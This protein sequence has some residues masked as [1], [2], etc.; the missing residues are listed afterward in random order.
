METEQKRAIDVVGA[1]LVA[2]DRIFYVPSKDLIKKSI[3]T[4][5]L[6]QYMQSELVNEFLEKRKPVYLGTSTGGSA[7]N[8]LC[9]L[10]VLGMKSALISSIGDDVNAY[11]VEDEL[12]DFEILTTSL[13]KKN[14]V[15]KQ[16]AHVIDLSTKH[17]RYEKSCPLCN[18]EFKR[19]PTMRENDINISD[20]S[21]LSSAK[22]LHIDR[23]AKYIQRLVNSAKNEGK[24][25]SLD[26]GHV[27]FFE[28]EDGASSTTKEIIAS[29]SILKTS[30]QVRKQLEKT[31]NKPSLE[32]YVK[33]AN[34]QLKI[35]VNTLGA[36][37][38]EGFFKTKDGE[39]HR[40][41]YPAL[42]IRE[43]IIDAGG[44]GDAFHA[45]LLYKMS[46]YDFDLDS[47]KYS[48]ALLF[49]QAMAYLACLFPG[50]KSYLLYAKTKLQPNNTI[51]SL[52]E[53]IAQG[54]DPFANSSDD[55]LIR[56]T[57]ELYK[58]HEI[59]IYQGNFGCIAC[60]PRNA[61]TLYERNIDSSLDVVADVVKESRG[62]MNSNSNLKSPIL[63]RNLPFDPMSKDLLF[64]VGSGASF[65]A[66]A[67]GEYLLH[68]SKANIIAKALTPNEYVKINRKSDATI[69]LSYTG[70][71]DILPSLKKAIDNK[72]NVLI[73]TR[74]K[75]NKFMRPAIAHGI[76]IWQLPSKITD[77]GFVTTIGMLSMM[78]M[79]IMMIRDILDRGKVDAFFDRSNLNKMYAD[80][81]MEASR[82]STTLM[83]H[84]STAY[85][86][87]GQG[88]NIRDI[89][90]DIHLVIL[91]SGLSYPAALDFEAKLT[92][93]GVC[94]SEISEMKNFTHGRYIN[95]FKNK[96]KRALVIFSTQHD[97]K[98]ANIIASKFRKD[99]PVVMLTSQ[100]DDFRGA[101]ELMIK[102]LYLTSFISRQLGL[103]L[104][105][106]D[107]PAQARGLFSYDKI[108]HP[109]TTDTLS[110]D[111]PQP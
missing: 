41:S 82:Q 68:Y 36:R 56:L 103:D 49:A 99:F 98:L 61:K 2:L 79:L 64:L 63:E 14:G 16:Y 86:N 26:L 6:A 75:N 34:P 84:L 107:Y 78:T 25:I 77:R 18:N 46:L 8:T 101:F 7:A 21:L 104:C 13:R 100:H 58:N 32:E 38:I 90:K 24:T 109:P 76:P 27:F 111:Q 35:Y 65:S 73:M 81:K 9:A 85:T 43:S 71:G 102:Q 57:E 50:A 1:G 80:G 60:G 45:G 37:G 12:N 54:R 39:I 83:E 22:I 91:A 70:R 96:G 33:E 51:V 92:E 106:P 19:P 15:T 72:E 87:N 94:T 62:S 110:I 93:G 40:F 55:D 59:G 28:D 88:R 52:V 89:F 108:Y 48:K 44:A 95:T 29:T 66:A 47:E 17:H 42:K 11:S 69:L 105:K 30:D 31:W 5:G 74:W 3:V 53:Q 97:L 4:D 23:T 67:F 10:S 20:F